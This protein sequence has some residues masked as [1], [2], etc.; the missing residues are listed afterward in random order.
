MQDPFSIVD[1]AL[2]RSIEALYLYDKYT[3]GANDN[4]ITLHLFMNTYVYEKMVLVR[5]RFGQCR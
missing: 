5:Q 4:H 2:Q 3:I 1:T